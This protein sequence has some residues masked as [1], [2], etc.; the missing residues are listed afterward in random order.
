[1]RGG[2]EIIFLSGHLAVLPHTDRP[3]IITGAGFQS[4]QVHD[5]LKNFAVQRYGVFPLAILCSQTLYF[6]A[7]SLFLIVQIT[8]ASVFHIGFLGGFRGEPADIHG[9][10]GVRAHQ[11]RLG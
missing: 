7:D 2:L 10:L 5:L 11:I 4:P 6:I 9:I 1:V 3:V 8:G